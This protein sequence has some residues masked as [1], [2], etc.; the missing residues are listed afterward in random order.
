MKFKKNN[1]KNKTGIL[2]YQIGKNCPLKIK[3]P[4]EFFLTVIVF[5]E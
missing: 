4:L 5:L 3:S 2:K 1:L